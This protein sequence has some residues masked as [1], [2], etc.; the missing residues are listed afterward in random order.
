MSIFWNAVE[1]F[2]LGY[3]QAAG[4]EAAIGN[5]AGRD[6]NETGRIERLCRQLGWAIDEYLGDSIVLHF[7]DSQGTVRRLYV[8]SGDEALVSSYGV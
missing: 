3:V 4:R 2:T 1:S 8:H 5:G 6:D 7:H